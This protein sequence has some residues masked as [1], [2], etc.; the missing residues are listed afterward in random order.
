[1]RLRLAS[2]KLLPLIITW[3]FLFFVSCEKQDVPGDIVP[4][5]VFSADTVLF[6]TI[7][8]DIGS[9]T[10][11]FKVFNPHDKAIEIKNISLSGDG[12]SPYRINVDGIPGKQFNNILIRAKDSLYIFIEATIDPLNVD[13]PMIVEDSIT[14]STDGNLQDVK[15]I[16]WGQDVNIL[17]GVIFKTGTLKA[18][19]PY[20]VYNSMTVDTGQ[21]LNI[22]PGVRIHFYNNSRLNVAGRIIAEGSYERP[23]VF[24]GSRTESSYRNI[25]GQWEGIWLMPGSSGNRFVNTRIKNAV[26]GIL[27]D[28]VAGDGNPVLYLAN[29]Q[30]GNMTYSGLFARGTSVYSYNTIIFGCG[31]H[32]VV[33]SGGGDYFFYHCTIAN[34]WNYTSRNSPSVVIDN[35]NTEGFDNYPE[36]TIT[37]RFGNS[38]V[39]GSQINEI[40]LALRPE[41][42]FDVVFDHCLL[43]EQNNSEFTDLF[44]NCINDSVPGFV[45]VALFNFRLEESSPAVNAGNDSTGILFPADYQ[46]NSRVADVA[47]DIGAFERVFERIVD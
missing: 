32:A 38:I 45:D 22:D 15:L 8:T 44:R 39:H 16:A 21:V 17:D 6:D 1:M 24:E 4:E 41:S 12:T 7:F 28:S 40:E 11:H 37:A 2:F 33:L 20:L 46:G 3:W 9:A 42:G 14:F 19:K 47:P 31:H 35:H 10:R 30:I 5:L 18:G 36:N 29:S 23:V 13:S 27:A 26:N 25:P 34:Y 43:P